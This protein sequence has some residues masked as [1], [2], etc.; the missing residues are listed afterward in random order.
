MSL[1]RKYTLNETFFGD[2]VT[3]EQAYWLGFLMAD[4][5]IVTNRTGVPTGMRLLVAEVDREH[6]IKLRASL[7][8]NAPITNVDNHGHPAVALRVYSR[9]MASDLVR[10][11]CVVRKTNGHPTPTLPEAIKHHFYRGYFDG[12]G[13]INYQA[14][15]SSWHWRVVGYPTF[16]AELQAWLIERVRVGRT[17]LETYKTTSKVVTVGYRGGVQVERIM[18]E[19]YLDATVWLSRKYDRF[20]TLINRIDGRK[21]LV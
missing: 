15:C 19:L 8:S 11:G 5:C 9:R 1:T 2:I 12:D 4:G 18:R 17:K 16:I 20:L 21:S 7:R 14:S 10:H 13:S 3:E 6:L